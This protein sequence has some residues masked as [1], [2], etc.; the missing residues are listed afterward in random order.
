MMTHLVDRPTRLDRAQLRIA[1]RVAERLRDGR[2]IFAIGWDDRRR[3]AFEAALS[4]EGVIVAHGQLSLDVD[5]WT[6]MQALSCKNATPCVSWGDDLGEAF[7]ARLN[8][9]HRHL[10]SLPAGLLMWIGG[11]DAIETFPVRAPDLWAHRASVEWVVSALDFQAVLPAEVSA[12]AHARDRIAQANHALAELEADSP[13]RIDPLIA[14]ANA[15][16]DLDDPQQASERHAEAERLWDTVGTTR[17]SQRWVLSCARITLALE[18]GRRSEVPRLLQSDG[19]WVDKPT[20]EA[21][22]TSL[23]CAV[24]SRLDAGDFARAEAMLLLVLRSL[25]LVSPERA[26]SYRLYVCAVEAK[27]AVLRGRVE[28]ARRLIARFV[29]FSPPTASTS[30]VHAEQARCALAVGLLRPLEAIR[31]AFR[32]RALVTRFRDPELAIDESGDI[33]DALLWLGLGT[34]AHAVVD[35]ML[36]LSPRSERRRLALAVLRARTLIACGAASL[37]VDQLWLALDGY[38]RALAAA[39]P[40]SIARLAL[41]AVELINRDLVGLASTPAQANELRELGLGIASEAEHTAL[42]QHQEEWARDLRR[43]EVPLLIALDR[44][45]EAR[46]RLEQ[47]LA[48]SEQHEGPSRIAHVHLELAHLDTARGQPGRALVE[49]ERARRALGADPQRLQPLSLWRQLLLEHAHALA[50]VGHPQEG[51]AEAIE[52]R[53]RMRN[54]GLPGEELQA[55]HVLAQ[56]LFGEGRETLPEREHAATHALALAAN[57][58]LIEEEAL[59]LANLAWVRAEQGQT[60]QAQAMLTE[61]RWLVEDRLYGPTREQVDSIGARV[62]ALL[63]AH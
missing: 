28:E 27:L 2:L 5:P 37:G 25:V 12:A 19:T 13:E 10:E 57:A 26:A 22:L 24:A 46:M 15:Y 45:V 53:D 59:A 63:V 14:S 56:P 52:A 60:A 1:R 31:H 38:R 54:A 7:F 36:S 30:C 11:L 50:A 21:H 61:A 35:A 44:Q 17:L 62:D 40:L 9:G 41:A 32:C 4:D 18:L 16:L 23:L 55:L 48:W 47:N 42:E 49:V 39:H 43:A 58:G 20:T 29:E 34:D 51:R 3:R 8:D 6:R 33:V